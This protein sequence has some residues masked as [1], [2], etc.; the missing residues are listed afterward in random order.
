[1]WSSCP[2][3]KWQAGMDGYITKPIGLN[4]I[5]KTLTSLSPAPSAVPAGPSGKLVWGKAEALDRLGG[6]EALLLELCQ[7]FLE[8]SPKQ[9]QK[10][11]QAVAEA[12]A[13]AVMRAAHCLKG[14][15]GYLGAAGASQAAQQLEDMGHENDLSHAAETLVVLEREMASLHLALKDPSGAI[16]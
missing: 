7:I 8:E 12:D 4:D 5:E 6:D 10:V 11:R 9:L 16:Q 13:Q 15:L 14:E 2:G 1:M 3:V